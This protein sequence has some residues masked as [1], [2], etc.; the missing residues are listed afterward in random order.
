MA[1]V[2]INMV[3]TGLGSVS[4]SVP[5]AG[6]YMVIGRLDLPTVSK[7]DIANSQ[8]VTTV[9]QNGTLMYTGLPGAEGF[10]LTLVCAAGDIILI[11]TSSSAAVDQG[12]NVFKV[13]VSIG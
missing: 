12:A 8:V 9:S 1:Q 4:G 5:Q 11:N 2:G 6:T 7:G 3:F 13:K 10:D